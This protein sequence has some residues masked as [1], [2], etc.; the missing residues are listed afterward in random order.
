MQTVLV[1]VDRSDASTRAIPSASASPS[2]PSGS[3]GPMVE[4][5]VEGRRNEVSWWSLR[6]RARGLVVPAPVINR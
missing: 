1:G 5:G 6:P 3:Q 4:A 2:S